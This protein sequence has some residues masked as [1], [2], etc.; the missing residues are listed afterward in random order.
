M[1]NVNFKFIL[2]S[3][4]LIALLLFLGVGVATAQ[5]GT[6][7][8]SSSTSTKQPNFIGAQQANVKLQQKLPVLNAELNSLQPDSPAYKKKYFEV[9]AYK[10]M[11]SGL[12]QGKPVSQVYDDA[13]NTLKLGFNLNNSA[14][15]QQFRTLQ[16]QIKS[17]LTTP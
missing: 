16:L 5:S 13:I 4:G 1:R 11:M 8:G 7:V 3:L 6:L 2:N 14:D 15:A 10:E 9:L 12:N 17:F